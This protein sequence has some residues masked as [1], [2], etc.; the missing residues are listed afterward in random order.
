MYSP[1][2]YIGVLGR[3]KEGTRRRRIGNRLQK[4]AAWNSIR[5]P[6]M[7]PISWEQGAHSV[8]DLLSE[9]FTISVNES[10]DN[11]DNGDDDDDVDNVQKDKVGKRC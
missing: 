6:P 1:A 7:H 4:G 9:D 5:N 8:P 2:A 11:D 10:N 3:G